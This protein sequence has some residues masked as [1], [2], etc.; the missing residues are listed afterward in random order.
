MLGTSVATEALELPDWSAYREWGY[1]KLYS[2]ISSRPEAAELFQRSKEF[3]DGLQ[4]GEMR[5][6]CV[7]KVRESSSLAG[8]LPV[9]SIEATLWFDMP[10]KPTAE[11]RWWWYSG[12][13]VDEWMSFRNMPKERFHFQWT[14]PGPGFSKDDA[15]AL[16]GRLI[17]KKGKPARRPVRCIEAT[18][19]EKGALFRH[20]CGVC[21]PFSEE[22]LRRLRNQAWHQAHLQGFE[23]LFL[24]KRAKS[25]LTAGSDV[26]KRA[27]ATMRNAAAACLQAG[28]E[29]EQLRSVVDEA[30]V[31]LLHAE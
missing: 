2:W 19:I 23:S 30:L 24:E 8:T 4:L 16:Y 28:L 7:T 1:D 11:D 26:R 12:V 25:M 5:V 14:D 22:A 29:V 31:S 27:L 6:K 13:A 18:M 3:Y 10:G 20:L 15:A 21:R 9:D 17:G